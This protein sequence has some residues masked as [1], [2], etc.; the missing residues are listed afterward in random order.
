MNK[1]HH[2]QVSSFMFQVSRSSRGF[3]LIELLLVLTIIGLMM[4]LIIPRAM[5]AQTD[6]KLGMVRQYGSEIAGYIMTWAEN[7]TSAQRETANFTLRD[8][9]YDDITEGEIGFS[10]KKLVDKYTGNDDYNQVETLIAPEKMPR[11]PFNEASYFNVANDD[12]LVPS[13]KPGLLYLASR[14]DPMDQDYLNFYLLFTSTGP[15]EK[16]SRWYGGMSHD[17][18][19]KIRRG[20]FVARLYD[21]TEYGGKKEDL[22]QWKR[23]MQ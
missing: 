5:R 23:R 1:K 18:D 6:S 14:K 9:F 10:S 4:A 7:Q 13:K 22:Y 15:D 16:G 12:T 2:N 17:D 11:N 19:N 21:D 20:V 3:T 8:F